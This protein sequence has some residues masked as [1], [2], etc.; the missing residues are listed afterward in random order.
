MKNNY[1]Y[2]LSVFKVIYLKIFSLFTYIQ[3]VYVY[4]YIEFFVY[5]LI[6][7]HSL[8]QEICKLKWIDY[9]ED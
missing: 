7:S 6:H 9:N 2:V 5:S 4:M 1:F 3:Y 8:S